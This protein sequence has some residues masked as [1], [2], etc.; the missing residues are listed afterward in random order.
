MGALT[1]P[2]APFSMN[3]LLRDRVG[4]L[5]FAFVAIGTVALPFLAFQPN[6]IL[7][8]VGYRLWQLPDMWLGA[9][10]ALLLI[11]C[12]TVSL[13]VPD[14]RLKALAASVGLVALLLSASL[15]ASTLITPDKPLARVSLGSGFWIALF[16]L[17][18]LVTNA[19]VRLRVRPLVRIALVVLALAILL[20]ILGSG[21]ARN[22]SIM[23]EYRTNHDVFWTAL[24]WHL[25]LVAGS[26]IPALAIGLP[27]GRLGFQSRR[28]RRVLIPVLNI[29]QT[30]PSI[31]LFG[32]LIAVLAGLIAAWPGL[33]RIGIHGIGS[34]PALIALVLYSLLP[35][36]TNTIA[37]FTGV[38]PAMVEAAR[39]MG[40]TR[41]QRLFQLEIPL[42]LPVILTGVRIVLVQNIG[43]AAVAALIGAGGLGTLVFRGMGQTA[44]DLVL[45]GA[46]PII[47]LALVATVLMDALV[48]AV[49]S[50]KR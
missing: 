42:A 17:G 39:G 49:D 7:S 22:L 12:G 28:V 26:L 41:R 30:T 5:C 2:G 21:V 38:D 1:H 8:G 31:A 23:R 46:G 44:M 50:R 4:L 13:T 20:G 47:I 18:L 43:L 25:V 9:G 27:L 11:A 33:T 14:Q 24:G 6:R 36:V 37:G 34:A 15:A 48:D 45:L 19:L 16:G 29:F 10:S 3:R 35:I 40:M 32:I